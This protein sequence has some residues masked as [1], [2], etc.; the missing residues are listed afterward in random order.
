MNFERFCKLLGVKHVRTAPYHLQSNGQA[1]KFVDSLKIGLRKAKGNIDQKLREF[2]SCYRSTPSYALGMKSP[3]EVLNDRTMKTRLD[4]LNP[5]GPHQRLANS[6]MAQQFN[7][8]HSA[9][10]KEFVEGDAVYYQLHRSIDSW[11]WIPAT[12]IKKL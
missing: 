12:V 8:H 2:L 10:W 7:G 6:K 1:E 5:P 9:K 3:A 11:E 4:L